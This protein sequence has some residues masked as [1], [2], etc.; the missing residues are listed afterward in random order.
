MKNLLA[1]SISFICVA[2]IIMTASVNLIFADADIINNINNNNTNESAE[3]H[4]SYYIICYSGVI[5]SKSPGSLH[6]SSDIS[7]YDA[8]TRIMA[9]IYKDGKFYDSI[10]KS[11]SNDDLALEK[12]ISVPKGSYYVVYEYQATING[13]AVETRTKTTSTVTVN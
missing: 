5:T 2:A 10:V 12:T 9:D 3:P 13:M 6:L 4:A 11:S 1:K 8:G 7:V